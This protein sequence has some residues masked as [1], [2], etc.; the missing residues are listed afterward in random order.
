M[1]KLRREEVWEVEFDY[2][3]ALV[4]SLCIDKLGE[5]IKN[6]LYRRY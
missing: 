3:Y 4:Q 5:D 6:T 2:F 1:Q